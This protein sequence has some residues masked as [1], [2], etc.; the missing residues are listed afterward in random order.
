LTILFPGTENCPA[1]SAADTKWERTN[2]FYQTSAN[3]PVFT[4]F[5]QRIFS[6][7]AANFRQ[8]DTDKAAAVTDS[9][10]FISPCS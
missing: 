1:D 5:Y 2:K 6:L 10:G 9:C 3:D 7:K 4:K 8:W